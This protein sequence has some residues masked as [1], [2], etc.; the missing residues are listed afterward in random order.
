MN[1]YV[2]VTDSSCD[3]TNEMA[4]EL[5]KRSNGQYTISL[6][7]PVIY[8]LASHGFVR[9]GP[10]AISED[11]RVR[12]YYEITPEGT[13]YLHQIEEVYD[14]MVEAVQ[15]IRHNSGDEKNV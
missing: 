1:E 15:Q 11:N 9:E 13:A 7:Y 5:E 10:K 3:L 4:N 2:I 6:L 14:Q 12:Q 8:R